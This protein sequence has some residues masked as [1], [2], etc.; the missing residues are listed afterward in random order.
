MTW[1]IKTVNVTQDVSLFFHVRHRDKGMLGTDE[2]HQHHWEETLKKKLWHTQTL[3]PQTE[4]VICSEADTAFPCCWTLCHPAQ[5]LPSDTLSGTK[6]RVLLSTQPYLAVNNSF[7]VNFTS[8]RPP[9]FHNL[10]TLSVFCFILK[11]HTFQSSKQLAPHNSS[12]WSLCQRNN[13]IYLFKSCNFS[14]SKST[15]VI[16]LW[17]F[18]SCHFSGSDTQRWCPCS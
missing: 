15:I 8:N 7:S 13:Q 18:Y 4:R 6:T 14:T 9:F 1:L 11:W 12:K 5:A 10:D 16:L 3:K 17:H 2:S